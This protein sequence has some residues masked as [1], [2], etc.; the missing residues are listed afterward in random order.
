LSQHVPD[1]AD[2]ARVMSY[3]DA[4]LHHVVMD[5]IFT[6]VPVAMHEVFLV[7]YKE[8]PGNGDHLE[9]LRQFNPTIEEAIRYAAQQSKRQFIDAIHA[10]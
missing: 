2:R 1:E 9:F 5:V 3:L 6:T 7:R 4:S 8:D 10:G